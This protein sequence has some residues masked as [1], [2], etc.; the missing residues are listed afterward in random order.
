LGRETL[1][2]RN[3]QARIAVRRHGISETREQCIFELP[4]GVDL[5]GTVFR[6]DGGDGV[7]AKVKAGLWYGKGCFP[8]CRAEIAVIALVGFFARGDEAKTLWPAHVQIVT[9]EL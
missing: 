3:A 2:G 7:L 4:V 9:S 6:S 1:R 5:D 8:A